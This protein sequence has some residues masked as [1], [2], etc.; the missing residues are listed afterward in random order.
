MTGLTVHYHVLL[1]IPFD[2]DEA[3]KAATLPNYVPTQMIVED[4]T[5]HGVMAYERARRNVTPT[6]ILVACYAQGGEHDPKHWRA[7]KEYN[8]PKREPGCGGCRCTGAHH[9]PD[10]SGMYW[11]Q[12]CLDN[13]RD[14]HPDEDPRSIG[15]CY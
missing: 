14:N 4:K 15:P 13:M 6:R 1:I 10:S 12:S 3:E 5:F 9:W 7:N 8:T 11:C 2:S